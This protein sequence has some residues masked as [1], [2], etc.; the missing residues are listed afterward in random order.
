MGEH[1]AG[2]QKTIDQVGA[3]HLTAL[4]AHMKG[5][6]RALNVPPVALQQNELEVRAS[7]LVPKPTAK[8]KAN[9]YQ[10]YREFI[11]QVPADVRSKLPTE[12]AG[13]TA[14]LSLLCNGR[15][16]ALD[17]KKALDAQSTRGPSDLQHV[18]NYLEIL[19]AAGLVEIPEPAPVKGG[20]PAKK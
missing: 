8:V 15:N 17:I 5:V 14:E 2:M 7:K 1:V 6:A 11:A 16:S 20:K 9:G 13:D 10:G 12:K 4:E 19:K 3:S 18:L